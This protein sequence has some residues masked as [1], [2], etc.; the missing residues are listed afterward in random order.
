MGDLL[1]KA[2]HLEARFPADLLRVRFFTTGH[3]L[4]APEHRGLG[5]TFEASAF[6][7]FLET[8]AVF[9][10][11]LR[12]EAQQM[13]YELFDLKDAQEERFYWGRFM[14]F[15]SPESRDMLDAWKIRQ[16][17]KS[18]VR[19]LYDLLDYVRYTL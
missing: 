5:E 12:P 17:P 18:Q 13:L 1:A 2:A 19:L 14:G 15:L 11:L 10:S 4:F 3:Q 16:W 7:R 6:L 8:A 9:R